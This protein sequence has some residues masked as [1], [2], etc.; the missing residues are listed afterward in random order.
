MSNVTIKRGNV[1]F[2]TNGDGFVEMMNS[3]AVK[4][5]LQEEG[6]KRATALT[7]GERTYRVEVVSGRTKAAVFVAADSY[8]A[9]LSNLKNNDLVKAL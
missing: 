2:V 4:S 7:D 3:S 1:K 9:R 6:S 5:L 8:E